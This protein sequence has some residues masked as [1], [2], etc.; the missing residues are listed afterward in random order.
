MGNVAHCAVITERKSHNEPVFPL[1]TE[2]GTHSAQAQ[3]PVRTTVS[4][5]A[6]LLGERAPTVPP[7]QL[8]L[9]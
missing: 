1:V 6:M 9:E 8:G 4:L 7:R 5:V 3:T 2:G